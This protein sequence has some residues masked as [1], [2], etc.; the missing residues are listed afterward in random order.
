VAAVWPG[1]GTEAAERRLAIILEELE[2]EFGRDRVR[3]ALTSA[4]TRL[5]EAGLY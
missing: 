5:D 4:E 1:P 2:A 3:S